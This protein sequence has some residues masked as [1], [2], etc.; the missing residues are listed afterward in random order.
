MRDGED[1]RE[2]VTSLRSEVIVSLGWDG[3][4]PGKDLP[5]KRLSV[6]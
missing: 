2:V 6:T 5:P 1:H 4:Q 3:S